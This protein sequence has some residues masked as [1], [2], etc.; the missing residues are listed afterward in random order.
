[1]TNAITLYDPKQLAEQISNQQLTIRVLSIGNSEIQPVMTDGVHYGK[2]P[3]TDKP[4]LLKPGAELLCKTFGLYADYEPMTQI[5]N[6]GIDGSQPLFYYRYKCLLRRIEDGAIVGTG[7][8]SCNSHES[9]Y[10]Y[11]WMPEH[12]VPANLDKSKLQRRVDSIEEFGFG[13][14][15]AETTGKYG[16][17]AEYWQEFQNAIGNGTAEKFQKA[18]K[19]GKSF[20]AYRITTIT[21]QVPNP[22]I[23]SQVN[24]ID[25]M[26]QKRAMIA[27]TLNGTAASEFFTQDVEDLPEFN[28]T[29]QKPQND[30]I[31][32]EFTEIP[33]TTKA[34]AQK[35]ATEQKPA[36]AP[37]FSPPK[38][39]NHAQ[40]RRVAVFEGMNGHFK[41]MTAMV[42]YASLVNVDWN[43]S[44][45]AIIEYMQKTI[46][47]QALKATGTDGAN[48]QA[49]V[50]DIPF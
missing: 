44:S 47:P 3:G 26:A 1:M 29:P 24:T 40:N 13:I 15:K 18:T 6:F 23:A 31:E 17:P 35:P 14:E 45:D 19:G 9:K 48:Y 7:I 16:K 10:G 36:I 25:K 46:D 39:E 49:P 22:E 34:A 2:I 5:E 27:A 33:A 43:L 8:G 42:N 50:D 4:T 21:Y 41:N 11:R 12:E 28:R 38:H 32:G 30:V 20:E 37:D